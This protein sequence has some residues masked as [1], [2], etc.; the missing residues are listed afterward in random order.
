ML[1]SLSLKV[2]LPEPCGNNRLFSLEPRCGTR[3]DSDG[4]GDF[5]V[6]YD[7]SLAHNVVIEN[8]SGGRGVVGSILVASR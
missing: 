6:V 2:V 1:R 8:G 3:A 7:Q 5:S 4:R